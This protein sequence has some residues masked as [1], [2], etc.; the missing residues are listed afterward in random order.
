MRRVIVGTPFALVLA[1]GAVEGQEKKQDK[2]AEALVVPPR[3]GRREVIEL[4]TGKDLS[5]WEGQRGHSA[6][7]TMLRA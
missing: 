4:L 5:G 1:P 3:P 2:K 6:F 7:T